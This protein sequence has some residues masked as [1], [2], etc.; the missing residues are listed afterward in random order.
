MQLDSE[1]VYLLLG[2]N[3]GDR[4]ELIKEAIEQIDKRIGQVFLTS[5]FYETSAWGKEDQPAFLNVAVGVNTALSPIQVLEM[6]LQI[7]LDLGRV[8]HEKW[9]S[10][11]IDID[12][13]LFGNKIVDNG[14]QLQ[15]PHPQMQHR[16]FVLVPLAEIAPDSIHPVFKLTVSEILERLSDNLSVSKV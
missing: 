6:V 12:I 13:V 16:K 8:R 9:G 15:I 14:S 1:N 10:R 3:L 5:A 7:E 11:L 2:S 4:S